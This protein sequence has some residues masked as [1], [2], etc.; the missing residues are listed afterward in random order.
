ALMPYATRPIGNDVLG[1]GELTAGLLIPLSYDLGKGVQL[2]VTA[3]VEAAADED[4][5]GR[6]LAYGGVAG[7]S[8]PLSDALGATFEIAATRD[9]DPSGHSTEW[10]AGLSA[11]WM[12]TD[13]LQLDAGANLGLNAA[14]A[15]VQL[16]FGISRRF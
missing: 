16:Y 13:D 3:Q 15:D 6:H 11:G 12:A 1:A 4:R 10:L 2:G 9:E 8:L 7:L 5:R 14:A